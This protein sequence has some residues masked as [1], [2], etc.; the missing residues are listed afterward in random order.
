MIQ[1]QKR[2][3]DSKRGHL[4]N[5]G[6]FS[7]VLLNGR[8]SE[9]RSRRQLHVKSILSL[10]EKVLFPDTC[11][12]CE[13]VSETIPC[14]NCRKIMEELLIKSPRCYKCGKPIRYKEQ[15][16]CSDCKKQNHVYDRGIALWLHKSPLS[17]ALYRMKYHNR[18]CYAPVIGER[19]AKG[20]HKWI[21]EV[22]PDVLLPVPL[23]RKRRRLRGYNQAELLACSIGNVLNL[24]VDT[25]ILRR[26]KYTNPQKK[27]DP[28]RRQKNLQEAFAAG[29][30]SKELK[31]YRKRT[32][33]RMYHAVLIID[34]IYTTGNT[35]DAVATELRKMGVERIYFMTASIG[36]GY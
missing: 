28:I 14:E 23:H 32:S 2:N 12:F 7:A 3:K 5:K 31:D 8:A 6:S 19:M 13:Q 33:A 29:R 35:I 11:P 21:E 1:I 26:V 4:F 30:V 9:R 15:E 17:D 25:S 34:D 16:Y 36:Q 18:R 27:L 24:P 20:L 22:N 10:T